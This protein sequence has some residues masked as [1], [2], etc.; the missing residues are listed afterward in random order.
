MAIFENGQLSGLIGPV[1][2]VRGKKKQIVRS[3]PSK[4]N[5]KKRSKKQELNQNRFGAVVTFWNQFKYSLIQKIWKIADE[6]GRGI[7][8]FISTN[9]PAFGADG[10]LLDPSRL[11]FSA[12]Q[13]PLPHRF[14]AVRS[15]EDPVRIMVSWDKDPEPG[16]G[17]ADDHL[18]LL[19]AKEGSYSALLNTGT[20]RRAGSAII[21]LP[22]GMETAEAVY[23]SFGSEKRGLYS[24]DVWFGI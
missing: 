11:H 12:G 14:T 9:M 5:S 8:P 15:S 6:G 19:A 2:A 16:A 10:Q 13:L 24:E 7:N 22:L 3:A 23:L 1:V 20:E 17:R 4:A 21:D 18:M